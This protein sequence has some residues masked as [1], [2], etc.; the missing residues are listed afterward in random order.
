MKKTTNNLLLSIVLLTAGFSP[1]AQGGDA[2]QPAKEEAPPEAKAISFPFSYTGEG[3]GN[4]SGGYKRGAVYD[5][6]LS[7]GVQG[8]LDKLIGWQGGSFLV[9]GLYPHGASL[10]DNYVHDFNGVSNI[11][12]YDSIRLYEA[13]FQQELADGKISIRVGQILADAE[14]FVSDNGTLFINGA[15][16]AIPLISQNFNAPVFP[17][18]TPGLRVRWTA[19]DSLSVQAGIFDGDV[20][21]QAAD[22][23]HGLDWNLGGKEGLLAITEVAYK[24][25]GEKD[26]EGL[27]GVYKLGVFFHSSETNDAFPNAPRESDA[28]GYFVVDQ[29]LWRKSG[30]ED[31]GLSGFLRIGGAP[32]DRNTVPFYFDTGFNYKGLIPG[33]D[34]DIAGLALSYTKLSADLCDDVGEPVESH[35]ETILEATYKVQVKDWLTIQPDIQYIFNPGACEILPNALVAGVRFNV[36]F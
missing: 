14:F 36:T 13:W 17:E 5:G 7:V 30:T 1:L 20:G 22:N 24:V 4:L 9:S 27:R 3:F 19:T 16:G 32:G 29:Q 11:D 31:Q 34:K 33:R 26:N 6:L 23:K 2:V 15:F 35:H 12:A 28:G 21:D 25:N 10:T 18:A 8:D